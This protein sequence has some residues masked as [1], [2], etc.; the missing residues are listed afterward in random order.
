M[1]ESM[2]NTVIVFVSKYGTTEK[3]ARLLAGRLGNGVILISLMRNKKPD[4][5]SFDT[6]ILGTSIYAGMPQKRMREFC[7]NNKE[8]LLQRNIGLFICG[9][10]PDSD[11]RD[12]EMVNA[13]PES[14]RRQAKA[15]AF[16][17]GE[18][19]FDKLNFFEKLVIRKVSKVTGS[20]SAIDIKAVEEFAKKMKR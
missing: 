2:N 6:I 8:I 13:Y 12:A 11:S 4:I 18:F 15:N 16:L 19:L 3:V 1:G 9:M 17:G 10:Q 14:L 20:I 5:S 7:K